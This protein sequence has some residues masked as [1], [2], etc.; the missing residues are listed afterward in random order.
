MTPA[1]DL[2]VG[3]ALVVLGEF[4]FASMGVA[5]RFV[6]GEV[7]NEVV[8]FFR[9]LFSVFLFMPWLLRGARPR[10]S[11][12]VPWLHLLRALAGLGAMYCF[13]YAI[14]R[15]PLAE[16]M[17]LKLTTPLFIPL[18]ALLWLRERITPTIGLGVAV[19]FAGVLMVL[20]PGLSEI[21]A[22]AAVGLLGGALAAVALVTVRRLAASEPPVRIV[23]WF[24]ALATLVSAVPLTWAW[25]PPS[26]S[27]LAWLGAVALL[28]T[29]GQVCLTKGLARAP[30]SR[31]GPF[32]YL[33]VIFGAAY[34]WLLWREPL[35]WGTLF[36]SL[37]VLV[38]GFI[39]TRPA[40]M[41]P[42]VPPAATDAG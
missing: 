2:L 15:I 11:T 21:S 8:V 40:R 9:N 3:A 31:V 42:S 28:A 1:R 32:A 10:F 36:G 35:A 41:A 22:V 18:I 5:I 29:L 12:R 33:A 24:A 30:A 37:L 16:A 13:F 6:A 4:L 14:A 19:G 34:G 39:L 7:P 20:R 25:Q 17:L 27:A 23:F 38:A 26:P